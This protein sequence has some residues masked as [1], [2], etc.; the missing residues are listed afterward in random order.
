[1]EELVPES[2]GGLPKTASGKVQK[3][4]LRAWSKELASKG[5]GRVAS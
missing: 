2:K 3:H 1:M 5:H 4:I